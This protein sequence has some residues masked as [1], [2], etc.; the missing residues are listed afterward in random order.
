VSGLYW[1]RHLLE[2]CLDWSPGGNEPVEQDILNNHG[3]R[4]LTW[5]L[6]SIRLHMFLTAVGTAIGD[7]GQR[8]EDD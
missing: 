1:P 7:E 5:F 8:H 4:A 3:A 2:L 6:N